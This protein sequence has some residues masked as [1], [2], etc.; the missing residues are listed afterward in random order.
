MA[1]RLGGVALDILGTGVAVS[2]L[3]ARVWPKNCDACN[4]WIESGRTPPVLA[5]RLVRMTAV[6]D[7]QI[8]QIR[9][10]LRQRTDSLTREG[11][12]PS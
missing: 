1:R 3:V 2:V 9:T 6:P 8:S 4:K 5:A 10:G 11:V 12:R 7:V